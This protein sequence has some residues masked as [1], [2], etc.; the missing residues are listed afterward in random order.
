MED[1]IDLIVSDPFADPV[2]ASARLATRKPEE[3][4]CKTLSLLSLTSAD[5]R[6]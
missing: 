1:C 3:Q 5:L 6:M 4:K 2:L